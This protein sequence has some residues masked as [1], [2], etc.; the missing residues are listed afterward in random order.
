MN[1]FSPARDGTLR[2][3]NAARDAGVKRWSLRPPLAPSCTAEAH[4]PR[5]LPSPIGRT[6]QIAADSS[7]YDRSK[8]LAE[9]AAWA[10][11]GAEDGALELVAIN[12]GAVLG[13]VVSSELFCFDKHCQEAS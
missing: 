12:P 13:P 5:P 4:V 3:L 10:W 1:L 9:R 8:T 7:P 11:H 2:V 6:K